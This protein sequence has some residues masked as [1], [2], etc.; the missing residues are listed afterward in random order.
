MIKSD[1]FWNGLG[2]F[3]KIANAKSQAMIK[4][5]PMKPYQELM[6]FTKGQLN[7]QLQ[8]RGISVHMDAF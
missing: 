8:Q 7:Y 4:D 2:D 5:P 6:E 3:A 1:A